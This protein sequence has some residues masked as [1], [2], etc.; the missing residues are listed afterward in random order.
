MLAKRFELG[1]LH[2]INPPTPERPALFW[3]K[4]TLTRQKLTPESNSL[5]KVQ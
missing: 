4:H 2:H 3:H 1:T 5:Y